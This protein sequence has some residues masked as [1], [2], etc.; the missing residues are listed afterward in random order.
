MSLDTSPNEHA[1]AMQMTM[2]QRSTNPLPASFECF[3]IESFMGFAVDPYN[4][5]AI[6][7][8]QKALISSPRRAEMIAHVHQ[9]ASNDADFMALY[10]ERYSPRFPTNEE[11]MLYPKDSFGFALGAHLETNG[12]QLDFQGLDIST[13]TNQDLSVLG[14][15]NL[16]G[17]RTHDMYH[18]LLGLGTTPIDEYAAASFTLG[19]YGSPYHMLLVST[20]YINTALE[21]PSQIPYFLSQIHRFYELGTKSK[22]VLGFKFEDH[23]ATPLSDVRRM[24]KLDALN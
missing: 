19:Q 2:K 14:Y 10:R 13:F 15:M 7:D 11:L 18:A 21:A 8:V 20:G 23:F 16:R 3:D 6:F 17:I 22:F 12:I 24:L 9:I 5:Q 1:A 4:T